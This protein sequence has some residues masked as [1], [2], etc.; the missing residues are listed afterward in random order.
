MKNLFSEIIRIELVKELLSEGRVEDAKARYP[1]YVNT[2]NYFVANDPSG[3]NKYLDWLIKL[4]V[5]DDD[6]TNYSLVEYITIFHKNINKF[7]KKDINQYKTWDEFEKAVLP[8]K[9]EAERKEQD[10]KAEEGTKKLFNSQDWLLVRPLNHDSSCKYGAGTKW[11]TTAKGDP[12]HFNSYTKNDLLVYLLHKTSNTKFAFH[13]SIGD[14]EESPVNALAIFNPP[15]FDVSDKNVS[16]F[17]IRSIKKFLELLTQGEMQNLAQA[18]DPLFTRGSKWGIIWGTGS[19]EADY[20]EHEHSLEDSLKTIILSSLSEKDNYFNFESIREPNKFL[21]F[22]DLMGV[23]FYKTSDGLKIDGNPMGSEENRHQMEFENEEELG[24]YLTTYL[25]YGS[26]WRDKEKFISDYL[27]NANSTITLSLALKKINKDVQIY[28]DTKKF[29]K[30]YGDGSIFKDI[31]EYFNKGKV[32]GQPSITPEE[33]KGIISAFNKEIK[34]VKTEVKNKK[35]DIFKNLKPSKK[36]VDKLSTCAPEVESYDDFRHC[37]R[38]Y[39]AYDDF[40]T[41]Q[42]KRKKINNFVENVLGSSDVTGFLMNYVKY[43]IRNNL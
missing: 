1:D 39:D 8:V 36:L 35:E 2:I 4:Y 18:E 29:R 12:Y 21:E 40:V 28:L 17:N 42:G 27:V 30:L 43:R 10:K 33:A 38:V 7:T 31:N 32:K 20:G 9:E 25:S 23:N 14:N 26:T 22:L 34:I 37:L 41:Y 16:G 11:C 19:Y 15:D 5:N 13:Y 24:Q 3:N 6:A